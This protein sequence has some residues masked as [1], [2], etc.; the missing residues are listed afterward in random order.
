MKTLFA[1]FLIAHGLVHA[2]YIS[3]TPPITD[4]GPEW[5]FNINKSFLLKMIGLN[6][7][8]IKIIGIIL[9]LSVIIGF[10]ITG[11]AWLNLFELGQYWDF[12]ATLSSVL[13]IIFLILFWHNWLVIGFLIN[14]AIL[15]YIYA[16]GLR[17]N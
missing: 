6:T 14:I 3:P 4:G 11:I 16:K 9:C 12:I 8:T 15:Y 17:V 5:P 2:F 1:L 13:S 10:I 7:E